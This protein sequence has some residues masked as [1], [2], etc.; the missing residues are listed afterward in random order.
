MSLPQTAAQTGSGDPLTDPDFLARIGKLQ[1]LARHLFR[2]RQRAERRSAKMGASLEFA[3]YR[4]FV[5]GDDL[6]NVDW[7]VYGRHDR[8]YLKLFEEE[9]DLHVYLLLDCSS[10]MGIPGLNGAPSKFD[11]ARKLAAILAYL[12]LS[13]LDRVDIY[14][15]EAG[16]RE[17]AGMR[18]GKQQFHVLLRFLRNLE[19]RGPS[20]SILQAARRF[21]SKVRH[22]GL[23]IVISDFLSTEGSEEGLDILCYSR[24]EVQAVQVFSRQELDPPLGGDLRLVDVESGEKLSVN[25]SSAL[26]ADY[27]RTMS[28]RIK[29]FEQRCKKKGIVCARTVTDEDFESSVLVLLRQARLVG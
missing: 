29:E 15:F 10:S 20:T 1:L 5:P 19:A 27:R 12:A 24:F 18:R 28:E 25:A 23:V 2:G 11:H 21:V 13:G 9:E 8:L 22:R 14:G 3:D 16:L 7:S 26:L 17:N 4:D 6:R